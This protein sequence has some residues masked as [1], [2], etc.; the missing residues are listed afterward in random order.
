MLFVRG[1]LSY[2][3]GYVVDCGECGKEEVY[4]HPSREAARDWLLAHGW[5]KREALSQYGTP[6]TWY[7][8]EHK[9]GEAPEKEE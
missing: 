1:V 7:C 9:A 4:R 6:E 5:T 3:C 2:F 8:P